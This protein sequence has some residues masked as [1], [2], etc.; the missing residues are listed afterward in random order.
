MTKHSKKYREASEKVD[1]NNLYTAS[2]AIALIK[3]MPKRGFDETI[4]AV[5][6]L[7]VDP[8]KADQL[9]RG[10][11]N[12]PNGTGKTARVAVFARGPKAS[13]ATEA[14]ADIVGDDDLVAKV[15]EGFLDFDAVVATP[16][17]M[18]K[19]GRL[20]RVLGP[21]GLMPNPKTGTVTMDVAKAVSDIKGGK[22]EFRVDKNGNLSF[23]IGKTSFDESALEE[24]F[25]VVAD[26]IKRLKPSTLK[27][28][29]LTKATISSTMSPGIP[30]DVAT[31]A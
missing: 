12:L 17:M 28:R 15:Q 18:G 26:E 4:E 21:R 7:N 6:C 25:K 5:Y 23:I 14:G 11:V 29:Y 13:E 31:L 30:L 16:D 3:S 9:V 2:E 8:R 20:G 19:V 22:I 27:G 10:V 1:R 24:N